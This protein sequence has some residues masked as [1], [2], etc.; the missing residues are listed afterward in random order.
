M[1]PGFSLMRWK[2]F[3]FI[4]GWVGFLLATQSQSTGL[5]TAVA[6]A[7]APRPDAPFYYQ[8]AAYDVEESYG[9][10][11][12]NLYETATDEKI[13]GIV[14]LMIAVRRIHGWE[15]RLPGDPAYGA[16]WNELPP[17]LIR[18]I[19]TTSYKPL[20]DPALSPDESYDFP[21]LDGQWATVT[22]SFRT[23]GPGQIDFDLTGLDV[24]AAKDGVIIYVNDRSNRNAFDSGAW[25]YWNV[26]I[27]EHGPHEYSLYGHLLHDSVPAW[28]KSQCV[29]DYS[30]SNCAVPIRA[31]EIIGQE[32]N[33]GYSTAP[34]LHIEFGQAYGVVPYM[35]QDG[36]LVYAG[37]IY[38]EQNIAFRGYT[39]TQVTHWQ[40]GDL[41][42]ASHGEQMPLGM[43]VVRNGDFAEG[44]VGWVASGQISWQVHDGVMRIMRL[45]TTDPPDWARFYQDLNYGAPA[46]TPLEFRISVGN[47]SYVRKTISIALLN[48]AGRQ[49]GI[50]VCD[51]AVEA[52]TEPQPYA[53]RGVTN[54]TWAN[55]RLEIGVNPPDSV[56]AALIRDIVVQRLPLTASTTPGCIQGV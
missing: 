47:D 12:L 9:I 26:V 36:S 2:S 27:I 48:S 16:V 4:S 11:Y 33:T 43:N 13:E 14:D 28:I 10:V 24:T 45:R 54:S 38:K 53:L 46:N 5:E 21:W 52:H 19:D 8:A 34:H 32:G 44:T 1:V 20:A 49:Y 7:I 3:I 35:D 31:G 39:V 29:A 17:G 22:R 6:Q 51:F 30:S 23:H 50:M 56:P 40:W 42:Q 41:H 55:V 37:Y 25:W 15:V 18:R